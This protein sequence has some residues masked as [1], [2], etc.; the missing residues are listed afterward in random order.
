[1][2]DIYIL[3]IISLLSTLLLLRLGRIG[4]TI[5]DRQHYF[6]L[7]YIVNDSKRMDM[8]PFVWTFIRFIDNTNYHSQATLSFFT[9]NNQSLML[10]GFTGL[11]S[12]RERKANRTNTYNWITFHVKP[13]IAYMTI[14]IHSYTYVYKPYSCSWRSL[15]EDCVFMCSIFNT[16][17]YKFLSESLFIFVCMCV[18]THTHKIKCLYGPYW[19]CY[20]F[21]FY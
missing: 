18:C 10:C 8:V 19:N 1:M 15:S 20:E 14:R 2:A 12:R 11:E 6:Q 21:V 3:Y 17:L 16:N 7:P 9:G 4:R 13:S 5:Y